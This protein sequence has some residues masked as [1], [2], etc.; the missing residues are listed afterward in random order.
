MPLTVEE[1]QVA[2]LYMIMKKSREESDSPGARVEILENHP[3]TDGPEGTKGQYTKK[4]FH[5]GERLPR[6]AT[7]LEYFLFNVVM[8]FS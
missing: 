2:Q 7:S 1:Y 3:Y 6:W 4:H 8:K 5:V